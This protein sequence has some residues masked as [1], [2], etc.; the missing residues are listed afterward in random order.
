MTSP[1]WQNV[2]TGQRPRRDWLR[3]WSEQQVDWHRNDD[4]GKAAA[5]FSISTRTQ[6]SPLSASYFILCT[7]TQSQSNFLP[8]IHS[9]F[10]CS[11]IKDVKGSEGARESWLQNYAAI[12]FQFI[13]IS[14]LRCFGGE[15]ISCH[16]LLCV[17]ICNFIKRELLFSAENKENL[18]LL[19]SDN[20]VT[21]ESS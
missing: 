17:I 18:F 21:C 16:R 14:L 1:N 3:T 6:S 9:T 15:T 5:Q 20:I 13:K 12:Y 7:H 11:R 2:Y 8:T 19:S 4:D 10:V